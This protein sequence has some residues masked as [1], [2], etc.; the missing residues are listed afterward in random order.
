MSSSKIGVVVLM[1]PPGSG[2]GTQ[3]K[4][5]A[6]KNPGW[7]HISTGDLF[8]AEIHSGSELGNSVKE[9]LAAGKLV[10]DEV[11][12]Q[13]F[14]AQVIE[15]IKNRKPSVLLLDGYPRTGPQAESLMRFCDARE[16]LLAPRPIEFEI[17]KEAV[18]ARLADRLVNPR[19][20]RVYHRRTNPPR[21]EGID[22]E[23]GGE[24][25]Q[26]D[27]DR[28][29]TIRKRYQIY[30]NARDEILSGLGLAG[31]SKLS[32]RA[33]DSPEKVAESFSEQVRKALA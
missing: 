1:G 3:A 4:R 32:L 8:R 22:D 18:V 17:S 14:E 5:A 26:R 12:D 13:V 15:I 25:I 10:S 33:E 19:T 16:D 30:T 7:A 6:E 21:V 2:K 29:E 27:D 11:T 20:G 9:I 28:P 24:L 23:D 31:K